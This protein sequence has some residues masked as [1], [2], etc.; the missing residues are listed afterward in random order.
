LSD[1]DTDNCVPT[2]RTFFLISAVDTRFIHTSVDYAVTEVATKFLNRFTQ[3]LSYSP[4]KFSNVIIPKGR[5]SRERVYFDFPKHLVNID[6]T[7]PRDNGLI[8]QN[9]F[10]PARLLRES[11]LKSLWCA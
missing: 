7:E 1:N 5:G 4:V 6:I 11:P 8:E 10:N 2:S 3:G 9:R